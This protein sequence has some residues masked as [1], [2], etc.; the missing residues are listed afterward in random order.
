MGR[1]KTRFFLVGNYVH[2]W[3]QGTLEEFKKCIQK[4][5]LEELQQRDN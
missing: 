3:N 4:C 2:A 5:I 1:N